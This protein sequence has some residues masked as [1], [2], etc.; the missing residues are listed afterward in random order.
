MGA[1]GG[2]AVGIV[3][4]AAPALVAD[5]AF[6]LRHFS[7]ALG[8]LWLPPQSL[9][10]GPGSVDVQ[11]LAASVRGCTWAFDSTRLGLCAR[12]LAGELLAKSRGYDSNGQQST[13]WGALAL[14]A[15]VDGPLL[16]H[17]RYRA[18]AAAIAPLR[19]QSFSIQNLGPL[20]QPPPLAALF[21]L[22]LELQTP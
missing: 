22:A 18:T 16:L 4:S 5:S 12:L 3:R 10:L 8:G 14:E 11:L 15:F 7:W 21:T 2:V 17:L 20:Y 1:A 13:P 19:D 9:E 6:E